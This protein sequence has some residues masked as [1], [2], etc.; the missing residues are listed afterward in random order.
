MNRKNII[1]LLSGLAV[2]ILCG[3]L[4]LFSG[5]R[6]DS[7]IIV[8]EGF[9]DK[10]VETATNPPQTKESDSSNRTGK[11]YIHV[12]GEVKKP[13]VYTFFTE[14]RVVEAVKKAGGFT[15]KAD[16]FSINQAEKITDGTQ[17]VIPAKGK[18]ESRKKTENAGSID[19][20]G[21][22][23]LNTALKEELMTLSGIG[24]SKAAQILSYREENGAF[25]KI[26][27]IMN[28]SGIKEGI[29]NRIKNQIVV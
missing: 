25:Q 14:P 3:V 17:L 10:E 19:Q 24:E 21:K 9:S 16:R 1:K 12:C 7:D 23:N 18:K 4:Y 20:S 11:I 2:V 5:I 15:G 13:G 26:E 28:I 6:D 8:T 29:F 22:V 27:D